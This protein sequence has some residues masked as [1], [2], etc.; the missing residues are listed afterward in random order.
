MPQHAVNL[1]LLALVVALLPASPGASAAEGNDR[2]LKVSDNGRFLVRPDGSPFFYLGDTAWELFH[3]LDREEADLYLKDRA[4]K[5][6]TVIQAVVLAEFNG[7]GEPNRY[8]HLPLK[9]NDPA[10]PIEGYFQ[11]V[12]YVVDKAASLGLFIGMLPTWGDKVNKKWGM[13]PEIFTPQNAEVFGEFLGQRYK[14]RPII[15]ILGGDRPIENDTHLQIWRGMAKGIRKGDG[16]RHLI[17]YHP[18]GGR[19][20][21]EWLH[22][23][24]W[25][26]LNT[27]QSGHGALDIPN[28]DMIAKDYAR[29]PVKPCMDSEPC[30]EDHPI[31]WDPKNGWFDERHARQAAYWALFAGAHGHTYGCHDVWQFFDPDRHPP[32]SSARTPWREAIKLP[33]AGQMQHARALLES[34]PFLT[35]VPDQSLLKSDPGAGGEHVA[36]TRDSEGRYAMVYFPPG[37]GGQP[38][39][40]D[41]GKIS[42]RQVRAWWFDPRT[43]ETLD[44]GLLD[45]TGPREFAE[46]PQGE[47]ADRRGNDWV[48]VLDDAG[49]NWDPPGTAAGAE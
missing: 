23:E 21:S 43:G 29:Q 34:R 28:Y 22:D 35:R 44:I 41:L 5:R 17:T 1:C 7:L 24:P 16:G 14:D 26:D 40:V 32:V 10:Q 39:T 42:G 27:L 36:A 4:D 12:D 37:R 31:N 3:R 33:A 19:H 13:G 46:P 49:Q 38:V 11:H 20:S 30:Y 25:L 6:F 15:W 8:G 47:N 45:N 9:D 2:S 48:L 18:M